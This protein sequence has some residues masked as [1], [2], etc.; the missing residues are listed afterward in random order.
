[1]S[2]A[3]TI[4]SSRAYSGA[5]QCVNM[6]DDVLRGSVRTHVIERSLNVGRD[7]AVES[8]EFP[9]RWI[10]VGHQGYCQTKSRDLPVSL[11]IDH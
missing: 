9:A 1:M 4:C 10:A 7:T 8:W 11:C 5:V 6:R 3:V 2:E